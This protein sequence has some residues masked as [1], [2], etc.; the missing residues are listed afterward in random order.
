MD[1]GWDMDTDPGGNRAAAGPSAGPP[2][3]RRRRADAQRN[4]DAII[5]ATLDLLSH[6]ALPSMSEI[7]S[8]AGVGRVTLYSHFASREVL[9]EAVVGRA[10][11]AT[12]QALADLALDED[13]PEIALDRVVRTSWP[14]LD[15]YRTVRALAVAGSE[16]E[17]V[18]DQHDR[19]VHHVE[20]LITRGRQEG[21]FR[22]DLPVP[23]LVAVFYATLHAAADE[24]S[25]GRLDSPGTPDVLVAT[26]LS[27]LHRS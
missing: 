12:D 15:R 13:P 8:A 10:I 24:V 19:V 2:A 4:A 21:V 23:W 16:P 1:T 3:R 5:D 9:L 18:R 11:T 26:L 14:I 20:R 27:I 6:G 25:A 17:I 7:A 22:I